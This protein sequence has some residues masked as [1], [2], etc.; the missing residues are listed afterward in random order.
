MIDTIS[1]PELGAIPAS[2]LA[3]GSDGFLYVVRT[4]YEQLQINVV[5]RTGAV[6]RTYSAER[7]FGGSAASGKIIMKPD[8][9][10]YVAD[11]LGVFRFS[12]Q[13]PSGVRVYF[14]EQNII[15]DAVLLPTGNLFVLTRYSLKEINSQGTLVRTISPSI[16][17]SDAL[18][19]AYD[20]DSNSIFLGM[21]QGDAV[22]R[23]NAETGAVTHQTTVSSPIDIHLTEDR[24]VLVTSRHAPPKF[25]SMELTNELS[26][27]SNEPQSFIVQAPAMLPLPE[28]CSLDVDGNSK[29]DA[30]TDGLLLLRAML[31]FSGTALTNGAIAN[32]Y[33]KRRDAAQIR[34]FLKMNCGLAIP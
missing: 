33:P 20:V 17:I 16:R 14:D 27:S 21:L 19:I 10:F 22:V 5:H 1:L 32:G 28:P 26:F 11:G 2:G 24:R 7:T 8:G 31:G 13:E 4:G 30:L 15:E 23:L 6:V 9:G 3:F 29:I 25:F 18:S 34:D 12:E